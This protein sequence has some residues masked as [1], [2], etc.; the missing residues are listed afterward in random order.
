MSFKYISYLELYGSDVVYRV[1][2]FSS[3]GRFVQR[4]RTNWGPYKKHLW[5]IILNNVQLGSVGYIV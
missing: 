2:F 1:L 4:S 5:E 3:G